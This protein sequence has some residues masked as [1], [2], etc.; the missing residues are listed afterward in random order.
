MD[1]QNRAVHSLLRRLGSTPL[2][3]D[4]GD[5][6]A[7]CLIALTSSDDQAAFRTHIL[8]F[9]GIMEHLFSHHGESSASIIF[10]GRDALTSIRAIPL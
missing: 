3:L 2:F 10:F 6:F 4:E 5:L 8:G 1:Y 7:A 9:V